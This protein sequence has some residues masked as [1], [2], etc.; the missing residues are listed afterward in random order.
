MKAVQEQKKIPIVLNMIN[1]KEIRKR[2]G[3]TQKILAKK[4]NEYQ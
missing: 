1:L 2:S 4:L 3:L